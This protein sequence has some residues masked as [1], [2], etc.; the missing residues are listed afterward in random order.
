MENVDNHMLFLE[1]KLLPIHQQHQKEEGQLQVLGDPQQGGS[2]GQLRVG[3]HIEPVLLGDW[4]NQRFLQYHRSQ[5]VTL[6]DLCLSEKQ[7]L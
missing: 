2:G 7:H 6:L 5:G 3:K 1:C 4:A